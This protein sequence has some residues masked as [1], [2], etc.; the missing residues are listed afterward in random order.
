M[1]EEDIRTL[2]SKLEALEEYLNIEFNDSRFSPQY[3][4]R[5]ER[6]SNDDKIS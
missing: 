4:L 3:T 5:E 6:E 2:E 1:I